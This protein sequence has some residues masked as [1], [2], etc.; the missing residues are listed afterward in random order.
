MMK[1]AWAS[2]KGASSIF[3]ILLLVVLMVFGVAALTV[4]LANARLGQKVSERSGAYYAVEGV[5]WERFAQI[6]KA[7]Q[8]AFGEPDAAR[9]VAANVGALGF[10]T[11]IEATDARLTIRYETWNAGRDMGLLATLV[12]D[13]E[14]SGSLRATQWQQIQ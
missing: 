13:L 8:A 12:L 14:D 11:D 7:A 1:K 5:A 10:E 6:D 4:A 3:V 9:A 2:R